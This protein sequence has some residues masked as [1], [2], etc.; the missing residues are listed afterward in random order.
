[1]LVDTHCHLNLMVKQNTGIPLTQA[2]M[3]DQ[4]LTPDQITAAQKIIVDAQQENVTTILTVGT[5]LGVTQFIETTEMTAPSAG[6]ANTARIFA[7]D[8]GGGK[9]IL[10]VQFATGAAQTLATEP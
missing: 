10:K 5:T 1:M 9:T 3:Q 6:A 2:L 7:V 4:P 8:S